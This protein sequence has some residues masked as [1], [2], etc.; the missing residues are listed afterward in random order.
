MW[1]FINLSYKFRQ[2]VCW[3]VDRIAVIW[4]IHRY[5][6]KRPFVFLWYLYIISLNPRKEMP[7]TPINLQPFVGKRHN[8]TLLFN[9]FEL[10]ANKHWPQLN[11]IE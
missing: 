11:S 4:G 9:S 10:M 6:H 1:G 2:Y 8:E 5:V 7:K 3:I